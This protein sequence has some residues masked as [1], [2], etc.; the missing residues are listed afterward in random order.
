MARRAA[1]GA[2]LLCRSAGGAVADFGLP[3]DFL[4]EIA[5]RLALKGG[6]SQRQFTV[7]R[8]GDRY[9]LMMKGGHELDITTRR[10]DLSWLSPSVEPV[11]VNA[12]EP[13]P[14]YGVNAERIGPAP[15]A[16][17][18][19][20]AAERRFFARCRD[21]KLEP[22]DP[23]DLEEGASYLVVATPAAAIP[24]IGAERRILAEARRRGLPAD[25]SEQHDHYAHGAP[26]R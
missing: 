7:V 8:R 12:R 26:R 18:P 15:D 23:A 21:G 19:D 1:A 2:I 25:L 10:G 13:E 9:V 17:P 5:P 6:T 20:P 14:A 4:R 16:A 3:A 22:I 11:A 24:V